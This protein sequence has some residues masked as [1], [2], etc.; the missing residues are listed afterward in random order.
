M[1]VRAVNGVGPADVESLSVVV[2]KV[3]KVRAP[4]KVVVVRGATLSATVTATGSPTPTLTVLGLES[5]TH[6]TNGSSGT[7]T[8]TGRAPS[9][10]AS[11]YITLTLVGQNLLGTTSRT[12]F[13]RL[14]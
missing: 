3:P 11:R 9:A 10:G 6:A 13:V 12:M 1:T 4:L 8:I 5:W 14:R 2:G 7:V